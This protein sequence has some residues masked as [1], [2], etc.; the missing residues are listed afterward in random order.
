MATNINFRQ[1]KFIPRNPQKYIGDP[2]KI[3]FM[4]SW[5]LRFDQFLDSNENILAWASEEIAIPYMK[6]TDGKVHRYYPDYFIKYRDKQG[7]IFQEIVEIKPLSQRKLRK[8]SNLYER[9]TFAVNTAKWEQ[10]EKFCKQRGI[11]FRLLS[12]NELF[13]SRKKI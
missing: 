1:G 9:L 10:A 2:N 13:A 7:N 12:E 6:P 4:S 11:T 3:R 8:N 5:E